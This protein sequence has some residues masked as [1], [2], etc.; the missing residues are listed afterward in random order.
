MLIGRKREQEQLLDYYHADRSDFVV[1][2]GRRRVG[3][4]FLVREVFADNPF[5]FFTGTTKIRTTAENLERFTDALGQYGMQVDE[6]PASW[7]KA[8]DLLRDR[9]K[10]SR[11]KGK[12]V[13]FIDEM[14]WLDLPRS[15]FLAALEYFWNSFASARKDIL[16]IACGSASSWITKKLLRDHGGLHNRVTGRI[17][18][19]PLTLDE[20]EVYL[21]T[22]G[23]GLSRYDLV[24]SYMV[25]GGIPYYLDYFDGR[26]SL[27]TN[28][29]RIV[30]DQDAPLR[31]EFNELYASLFK[32]S[33]DYIRVVRALGEK[34]KGLAR[35]EIVEA[36]GLSNGGMLSDILENLELSGFIRSYYAYPQKT[37]GTLYQL[38]DSFSLFDCAFLYPTRP[39]NRHFWSN[40]TN[41][42]KLNSWRGYAFEIVCLWH[43][44]QIEQGLG[45][46]GVN[47]SVSSWKSSSVM[48]GAQ[49]DL[50]IDREDRV[51]NLC[52]MKYAHDEFEVTARDEEVLRNK[53]TAFTQ[54]TR[55]RKTV[56]LTFV[57]PYG[58]KHGKHAGIVRAQI[59]MDD[60][61]A[62]T[63]K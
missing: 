39:T 5:L 1:V 56:F 59:T 36:S 25:F 53:I 10:T 43:I 28:I 18:L 21:A 62:S 20:C 37:N 13:I 22:K 23:S 24:E 52:E 11:S 31:D 3:K 61:F 16:L 35:N 19:Q 32:N 26:Y 33:N 27:A 2:Y 50:V 58:V 34:K 6:V 44:D 54:E 55:T 63:R 51:V 12:K 40:Q 48:P 4:T 60:L 41:T 42:P 45:I 38:I 57:A 49:I 17:H 29:D 8:F 47:T 30:F 7:M 14:P 46:W 15:G 9:I